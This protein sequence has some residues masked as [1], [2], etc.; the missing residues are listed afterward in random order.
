M[1]LPMVRNAG[2]CNGPSDVNL[3]FLLPLFF[4]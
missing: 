1:H 2:F 4:F 3:L